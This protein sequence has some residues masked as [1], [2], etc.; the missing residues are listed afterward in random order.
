MADKLVF[1]TKV[2]NGRTFEARMSA[3]GPYIRLKETRD[4]WHGVA[5]GHPTFIDKAKDGIWSV[6]KYGHSELRF[7]MPN[8]TKSD[9]LELSREFGIP[10]FPSNGDTTGFFKTPAGHALTRWVA[11]HPRIAKGYAHLD[12]YI[13]RWFERAMEANGK[14]ALAA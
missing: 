13:P 6:F 2:I 10:L 9:A 1:H 5:L 4:I 8:F 12:S 7:E 11:A 3:D 14:S